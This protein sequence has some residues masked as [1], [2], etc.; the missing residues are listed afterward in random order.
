MKNKIFFILDSKIRLSIKG[1]NI[2]R[3]IKRLKTNN[4]DILNIK[5][6]DSNNIII[7]IYYK[8]YEKL[9]KIKTVY[10]V[11]VI[12]YKGLKNIKEKIFNNKYI[13][14]SILICMI[15]LYILSNIVFN[16]EVITNDTNMKQTLLEELDENG[17]KK[18]NFKK[19]YFF[20][21]YI[22]F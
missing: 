18:Y 6:I 14:I 7:D 21:I 5:Y 1:N 16:I 4:I 11:D 12:N 19:S 20:Q 9:L 2:E 17:L 10:E 3:F 8:N 22:V 15:F 13:I